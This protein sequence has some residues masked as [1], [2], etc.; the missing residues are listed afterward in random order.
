MAPGF[1]AKS[2]VNHLGT[3]GFPVDPAL[4]S[5]ARNITPSAATSARFTSAFVVF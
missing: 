4:L 2:S 3:S 5:V 1:I